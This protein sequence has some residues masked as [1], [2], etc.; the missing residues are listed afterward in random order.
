MT[1]LTKHGNGRRIDGKQQRSTEYVTWVTM[2]Q[3]CNNPNHH[4][5]P[6][7]GGRGVVVCERW[8]EFANF[9]TDMGPKPSPKHSIDRYPNPAG[10]YEPGNCRWATATEQNRNRGDYTKRRAWELAEELGIPVQQA[11][12]ILHTQRRKEEQCSSSSST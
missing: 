3:R 7:Y 10:N 11:S 5:Y 2:R 1:A 6:R 12:N 9:L 4:K 8:N